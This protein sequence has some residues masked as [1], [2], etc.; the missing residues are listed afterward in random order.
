MKSGIVFIVDKNPVH[1][2]LLKYNLTIHRFL[3]VQL[4]HSAEEC[5]SRLKKGI[6]PSFIIV[7]YELSDHTSFDFLH[8]IKRYS[9]STKI[10]FFSK[11][12][13]PILAMQLIDAGATDYIL[14]S[15][16]L[17]VSIKNLVKNLLFLEKEKSSI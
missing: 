8:R 11:I 15:Q 6:E 2:S 16:Q 12:D 5:V 13:D 17:D 1:S 14:K 3:N 9:P 4:Y 7:D 10:I